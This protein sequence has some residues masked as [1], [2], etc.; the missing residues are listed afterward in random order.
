MRAEHG[1]A[2]GSRDALLR[3]QRRAHHGGVLGARNRGQAVKRA[4]KPEKRWGWAYIL[5]GFP[6]SITYRGRDFL[7]LKESPSQIRNVRRLL[8]ALNKL[9]VKP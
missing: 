7:H 1:Q 8:R 5:E 6:A 9:E 4:K 2:L 3:G